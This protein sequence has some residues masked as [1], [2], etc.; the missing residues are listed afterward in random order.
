MVTNKI[1]PL[2]KTVVTQFLVEV[3]DINLRQ[4]Q[5][6]ESMAAGVP[7][8]SNYRAGDF[9]LLTGQVMTLPDIQV[10]VIVHGYQ[11]FYIDILNGASASTI[12]CTGLYIAYGACTS[13]TLRRADAD[14]RITYVCA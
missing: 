13:I 8:T 14:T 7:R 10:V 3:A 12:L 4:K 11:P 1:Q 6:K 2:D 9:N 5:L